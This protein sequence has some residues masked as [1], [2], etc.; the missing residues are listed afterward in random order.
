MNPFLF[1][2]FRLYCPGFASRAS[3][4]PPTTR[5]SA[6]PDLCLVKIVVILFA[7][8]ATAPEIDK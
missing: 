5:P 2:S 1:F 3:K 6:C 4:A 7:V 8:T